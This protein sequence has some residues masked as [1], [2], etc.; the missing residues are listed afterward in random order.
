VLQE[1]LPAARAIADEGARAIALAA[2]AGPWLQ[3]DHYGAG[4]LMGEILALLSRG[5]RPELLAALPDL[6][7]VISA[8]GGPAAVM[9]VFHA[10]KDV[11]RWWP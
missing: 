8:L 2:L 6:A 10:I 5:P 11:C 9:E 7:P 4:D 1:A 3:F